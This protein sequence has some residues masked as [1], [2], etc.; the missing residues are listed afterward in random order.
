[1]RR[2]RRKYIPAVKSMAHIGEKIPV[3]REMYYLRTLMRRDDR[4][5]DT[6]VRTDKKVVLCLEDDRGRLLPP[7]PG[8]TTATWMLP[9][10]KKA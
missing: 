7:T 5:E 2:H 3:F 6:V 4:P 1:M 9:S 8:S 10:G